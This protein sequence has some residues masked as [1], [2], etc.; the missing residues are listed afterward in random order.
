VHEG[1]E[2]AVHDGPVP[3]LKSIAVGDKAE[4]A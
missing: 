2:A 4:S 3:T 1:K